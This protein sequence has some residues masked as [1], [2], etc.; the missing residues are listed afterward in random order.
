MGTCLLL[1]SAA[2]WNKALFWMQILNFVWLWPLSQK[3]SHGLTPTSLSKRTADIKTMPLLDP[4]QC[5]VIRLYHSLKLYFLTFF[6]RHFPVLD[7]K[8]FWRALVSRRPILSYVLSSSHENATFLVKTKGI[9]YLVQNQYFSNF[10]Q[11][12][13]VYI[14]FS[15]TDIWGKFQAITNDKKKM[16]CYSV[17]VLYGV[18]YFLN[19]WGTVAEI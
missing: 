11:L 7:F 14:S 2:A 12:C 4:Y 18:W 13:L 19:D 8:K 3:S 1:H 5:K 6:L 15:K 17:M 9:T 16:R 10:S